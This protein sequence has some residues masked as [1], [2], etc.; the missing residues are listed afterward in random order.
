MQILTKETWGSITNIKAAFKARSL[1]RYKERNFIIKK[2]SHEE[3]KTTLNLYACKL[4][5][6]NT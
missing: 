1:T 2:S 3:K 4:C 6:Q 5:V